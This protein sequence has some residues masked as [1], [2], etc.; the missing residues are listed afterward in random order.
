MTCT[1]RQQSFHEY[2]A[3]FQVKS[4]SLREQVWLAETVTLHT[5]MQYLILLLKQCRALSL[6]LGHCKSSDYCAIKTRSGLALVN[7]VEKTGC[8]QERIT[9]LLDLFVTGMKKGLGG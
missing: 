9:Y 2:Y 4:Q 3:P 1:L 7:G 5:S 6:T 8:N